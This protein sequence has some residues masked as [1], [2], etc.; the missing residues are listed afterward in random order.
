MKKK[1]LVDKKLLAHVKTFP[2]LICGQVPGNYLNPVDP[3]HIK[4]V[5]AGGPDAAFN[6]IP[7]CRFHHEKW[8]SMGIWTFFE[9]YPHF[10][11]S[12]KALGWQVASQTIRDRFL[13]HPELGEGK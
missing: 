2:C 9:I 8:G 1:R 10:L 3:F 7:C 12:L 13:W 4:S 11:V 6:V 5:G